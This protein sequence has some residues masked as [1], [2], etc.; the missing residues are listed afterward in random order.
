MAIQ[1]GNII[2]N[3]LGS[4]GSAAAGAAVSNWLSDD[5]EYNFSRRSRLNPQQQQVMSALLPILQR[6]IGMGVAPYPGQMVAEASPLQQM[7]FQQGPN[8]AQMAPAMQ[9]HGLS[10]MDTGPWDQSQAR[11]LWQT[12]VRDPMLEVWQEDVVPQIQEKYAAQNAL[13]SGAANRAL[14][15][16]GEDLTTSIGSQLAQMLYQDRQAHRDYSLRSQATGLDTLTNALQQVQGLAGIGER[17]R[18]IKQDLLQEPLSKWQQMQPYN[19]PWLQY[20]GQGVNPSYNENFM[21]PEATSFGTEIA[22]AL[23]KSL[24][25][26]IQQSIQKIFNQLGSGQTRNTGNFAGGINPGGSWY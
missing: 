11:E 15:E 16:S 20:F 4:A 17:Q 6:E 2:G 14:A 26:G 10:M 5:P 25:T 12:S 1:W 13:S 24:G 21:T 9:Q 22:P 23:G 19:N 7:L 3:V 8:L 18:A